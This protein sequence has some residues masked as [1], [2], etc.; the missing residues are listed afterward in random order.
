MSNHALSLVKS[1]TFGSTVRKAIALVLA[2]Y[3]DAEWST[4]AGQKLIAAEA[5]TTDRTVRTVLADFEE[6]GLISR[7]QRRRDD[8]YRTSDRIVMNAD[9]IEALP[10]AASAKNARSHRKLT[11]VSPEADDRS[12]RNQLPGNE[13]SVRTISEPSVTATTKTTTDSS[14][15]DDFWKVYPLKVAKGQARKAWRAAIKKAEPSAIIA[16]A[17]RY[18]RSP[19]RKPEFTAHPS[20][21]LNGERWDDEDPSS[22]VSFET[23]A[24]VYR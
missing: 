16:A 21:W 22:T 2:D 8:G 15:F 11:T 12:H 3:A 6:Q 10:E 17:D 1:R 7:E 14:S 24:V 23:Q 19:Y 18:R 20:T 4:F 13:P 5:E 9:A